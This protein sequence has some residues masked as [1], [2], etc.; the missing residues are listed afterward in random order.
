MLG[1]CI[2]CSI[3]L[4]LP[5]KNND[6][7]VCVSVNECD[8]TWL[9]IC[10]KA[11]IFTV[12]HCMNIKTSTNWT[13][14]TNKKKFKLKQIFQRKRCLCPHWLWGLNIPMWL[15]NKQRYTHTHTHSQSNRESVWAPRTVICCN[16]ELWQFTDFGVELVELAVCSRSFQPPAVAGNNTHTLK[17]CLHTHA[18][19]TTCPHTLRR[20]G[21]HQHKYRGE[22]ACEY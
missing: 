18:N 8:N 7:R 9:C 16:L 22:R 21:Q 6:L 4:L 13:I 1:I 15:Q 20:S 3:L 11:F 12:K 17:K 14:P 19:P 10:T 2:T 5:P